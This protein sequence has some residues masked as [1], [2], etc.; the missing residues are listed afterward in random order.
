M[1]ESPGRVT[2]APDV[3]IA[4]ARLTTL[5]IPGVVR[6]VPTGLQ[7]FLRRGAP[8]GV[9]VQVSGD[10][11]CYDLFI[12]A[13]ANT[14]LRQVGHKIQAEVARATRDMV[15]MDIEAINVHIQDVAFPELDQVTRSP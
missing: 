14:N 3:L 4:I 13:D 8:E 2:I 15:G 7:G 5:N 6:M 1:Y 11:V 9:L 10:C 12:V